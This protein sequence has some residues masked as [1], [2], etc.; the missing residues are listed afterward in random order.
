MTLN[1]ISFRDATS[2]QLASA[3]EDA[4]NYTLAL[5]E[6]FA[7]ADLAV[8]DHVPM[9]SIVNPP[10]WE[11]GH[12]AWFAEWFVLRGAK[13]SHPEAAFSHS[14]ATQCAS[15]LSDSDHYLDSN[16]VPHRA[17]W[18]Q[19]LPDVAVLKQYCQDV[20]E[21]ILDKLAGVGN[22]AAML[23]PYRL[24]LAHEDMHGEA[25]AYTLQ[26]LGV[27]A[28]HSFA[29]VMPISAQTAV[30][31][32]GGKILL[33]AKPGEGFVFDNEKWAHSVV[34]PAFSIDS[35]LVTNAQYL[36]FILAGGYEKPVFWST[37]GWAA[38]LQQN[39]TTPRYWQCYDNKWYCERFGMM[40]GLPE[41]EPVRH[42]G[43]HAAQAYCLWAGRRLPAEAEWEFAA[44]SANTAFCWGD[45]WEWTDSVFIP[46]PGFSPDPY[47]EYSASWFNTHQ[48]LRG[49]SFVTRQRMRSPIYR[50]FYLPERDDMFV[51]FRTC[52]R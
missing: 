11:L 4:R 52:A 51:G 48:V 3:L 21:R 41:N 2:Q 12:I 45:L 31:F 8:A 9:L 20:L 1:N 42:V 46:Y 23:Y 25:F 36:Q 19:V 6:C 24:V 28:S 50:N 39:R 16:R 15:L 34:V 17:R 44:T 32:S 43:F 38:Q 10:L 7:L 18:T 29:E 37:A 40:V 30:Q 22:D 33:G 49:A 14:V 47:Q 35:T 27:V 26:T 13:S 5:F